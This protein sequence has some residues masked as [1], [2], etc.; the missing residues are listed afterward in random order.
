MVYLLD[1]NIVVLMIRGLKVFA[2]P[3]DRQRERHKAAYR[4][5]RRA[6]NHKI[7]G[8][9]V[10]V[11]AITVAELEFGSWNSPD[12]ESERDAARRALAPFEFLPFDAG[13]C[14]MQYGRVRHSLESAGTP[15]GSLDT[16]IA[17]H[18]LAVGAALIASDTLEFS[19]VPGLK[20][21]NWAL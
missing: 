5:L 13:D 7:S 15:I 4:I 14:A 20:C 17:A 21:E 8:D 12:Y 10:G 6:R 1:T 11:S 2:K 19:R 9:N 18:A 16:L 3:N